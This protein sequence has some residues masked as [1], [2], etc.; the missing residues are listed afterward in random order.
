[1][2][3]L[4]KKQIKIKMLKLEQSML[5]NTF[6][7]FNKLLEKGDIQNGLKEFNQTLN[8]LINQ[9]IELYIKGETDEN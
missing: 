7:E 8:D 6:D 2:N 4:L 3:Y 1:M 9:K 5:N